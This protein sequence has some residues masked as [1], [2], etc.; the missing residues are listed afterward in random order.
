MRALFAALMTSQVAFGND[1]AE[2]VSNHHCLLVTAYHLSQERTRI[3]QIERIILP[4]KAKIRL[5]PSNPCHPCSHPSR[6]GGV[7][8]SYVY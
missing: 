4:L 8:S 1:K 3:E 7:V 5:N 2:V 6:E